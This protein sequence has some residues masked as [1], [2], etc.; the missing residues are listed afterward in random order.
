VKTLGGP[1]H[2]S[3]PTHLRNG[4]F[5]V[6]RRHDSG[7]PTPP[8]SP[9]LL[10][11]GAGVLLGATFFEL[12]P[13]ALAAAEQQGWAARRVLTLVVTGFLLFYLTERFL[14]KHLCET[15]D[16]GSEAH[17]RIGR[18]SAIG[19]IDTQRHRW[20]IDCRRDSPLLADWIDCRSGDCRPRSR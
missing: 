10:A 5:H 13:E 20:S 3:A 19:L 17:R 12:L 14:V 9:L 2:D 8:G 1:A 7:T 11:F 18:M 16:C 15:G 6:H 4:S